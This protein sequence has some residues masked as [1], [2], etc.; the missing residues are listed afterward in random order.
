MISTD[1][2][3]V[4]EEAFFRADHSDTSRQEF[5]ENDIREYI[6]YLEIEREILPDIQ[7]YFEIRDETRCAQHGI[8]VESCGCSESKE[9]E[10]VVYIVDPDSLVED[11][12]KAIRDT[13][14]REIQV[15]KISNTRWHIEGQLGQSPID[16]QCF[17]DRTEFETYDFEPHALEFGVS[18]FGGG[19]VVD[20][21][22]CYSWSQFLSDDFSERLNSDVK[23]LKEAIGANFY[24]YEVIESFRSRVRQSLREYFSKS[25]YKIRRE[26]GDACAAEVTRYSIP[27]G[28]TDFVAIGD[29]SKFVICHCGKSSGWH[30]HH[31][32]DGRIES[33]E[34]T[35]IIEDM[36]P[37]IEEKI[38][39]FQD[40]TTDKKTVSRFVS[41]V[42]TFF[43]IGFVIL[44]INRIGDVATLL[45]THL[46]VD[47]LG[48]VALALLLL[49]ALAAIILAVVIIRPYY[50][51]FRFSWQIQPY[52]HS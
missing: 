5:F 36:M 24:E 47:N 22:Y 21:D 32:Y 20:Q 25:G 44:F 35:S 34:Q 49:D 4:I 29:T 27:T 6:D 48:T 8:R 33:A 51:D 26:V 28:Q 16:L 1:E 18:F 14:F 13:V 17:F 7:D 15:E 9:Q 45:E 38:N 52:D 2:A 10:A 31:F 30:I 19:E 46:P 37:K 3:D 41:V 43:S 42:A 23:R 50:R 39:T 11:W 40:I 12:I